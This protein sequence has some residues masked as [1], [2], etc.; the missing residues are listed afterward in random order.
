MEQ[1]GP[2]RYI[3]GRWDAIFGC[4]VQYDESAL[5]REIHCEW[6][7]IDPV[8]NSILESS[9]RSALIHKDIWQNHSDSEQHNFTEPNFGYG[10][11]SA[12]VQDQPDDHAI[13]A[14]AA[15]VEL[16]PL[17]V[18]RLAATFRRW[19]WIIL[20]SMHE[21]EGFRGFVA[22]ELEH[23]GPQFINACFALALRERAIVSDRKA[24]AIA[25]MHEPRV[26]LLSRLAD[27]PCTGATLRALRKLDAEAD[28]DWCFETLFKL[29]G[30]P[31]NAKAMRHACEISLQLL[32]VLE[33]L[34]SWLVLPNLVP[35][36]DS[37]DV[38]EAFR[39]LLKSLPDEAPTDLKNRITKSLG[40]VRSERQLMRLLKVWEEKLLGLRPFP[41]PPFPGTKFLRPLRSAKAM[42]GEAHEMQNCLGD[43]VEEVLAGETY[44]YQWRGKERATVS[45]ERT[46][47]GAWTLT[48]CRTF[49]DEF[50]HLKTI[51]EITAIMSAQQRVNVTI[52]NSDRSSGKTPP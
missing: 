18:R 2:K 50:A 34:P 30:I 38:F 22:G 45:I 32:W 26:D 35:F 52:K 37:N 19:Q 1:C 43:Y 14:F 6:P 10:S 7:F 12:P 44:F 29:M 20:Y 28:A 39:E 46:K 11:D 15:Y 41:T 8:G 9:P 13:A 51:A 49:D 17:E 24:I 25:I 31:E 48:E 23:S 42:R 27:V 4:W 16:I 21:V 47:R 33:R 5:P 3:Y 40:T 36:F